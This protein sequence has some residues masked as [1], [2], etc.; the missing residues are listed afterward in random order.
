[1]ADDPEKING[2]F[3]PQEEPVCPILL[4]NPGVCPFASNMKLIENRTV[5]LLTD[6]SAIKTDIGWLKGKYKWQLLAEIGLIISILIGVLTILGG[7]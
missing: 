5:N 7:R 4:P 3:N 2:G 6:V 1:M